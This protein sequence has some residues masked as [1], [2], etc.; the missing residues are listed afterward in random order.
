MRFNKY[1]SKTYQLATSF[2]VALG[3][4][5]EERKDELKGRMIVPIGGDQSG[6]QIGDKYVQY[7]SVSS[8]RVAEVVSERDDDIPFTE[9]DAK[10][11]FAKLH[12]IRSGHKFSIAEKDKIISVEREKQTK[13]FNLKASETFYAISETENKELLYGNEKLDRQGLLTV[14]GKRS[15]TLGVNLSTATGEQVTDAFVK[16]AL[17]FTTGAKGTYNARTLVIDNT[18]H[19]ELMKS[20]GTQEYKTRLRVIEELGLFGNIVVVKGLKNPV[21]QKATMLILDNVPENF[22]AIVVQEATGDEWEIGRTTYVAVE[23]KISEIVAFRPESI[24]EL[25]TA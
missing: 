6:I 23:E 17:E 20:Y 3:I 16:A 14:D 9:V 22:Q 21:S 8:R 25:I 13:L 12:W 18:L 4:V 2:M 24:M 10:D 11:K 5:L 1:N 19:A 7:S 15:F